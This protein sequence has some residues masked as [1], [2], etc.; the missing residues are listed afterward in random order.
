MENA[1]NQIKQLPLATVKFMILLI[2]TIV[3]KHSNS[4][5]NN[6]KDNHATFSQY[7]CDLHIFVSLF[8]LVQR[9]KWLMYENCA[10]IQAHGVNEAQLLSTLSANCFVFPFIHY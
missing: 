3:D 8:F 9:K 7:L 2:F 5:G 1:K 10:Q 6:N 4:N